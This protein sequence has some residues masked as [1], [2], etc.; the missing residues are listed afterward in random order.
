MYNVSDFNCFYK[1][2]YIVLYKTFYPFW[3][4]RNLLCVILKTHEEGPQWT[5]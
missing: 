4:Q 5:S 2:S 1:Y 3:E